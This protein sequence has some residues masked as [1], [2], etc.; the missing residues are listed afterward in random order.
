LQHYVYCPRQCGLI[1]V[2]DVWQ[3]NVFT[4]R[5]NILHEKVDTDTYE[6]RGTTKTVRGLRI[7][8]YKFGITGRCDVVEFKETENGKVV[9]PVEFK[10]GE[11]KEDI[12][13]K[14]QLCAQAICLEEML[15]ITIKQ[16]FFFYGKIR[17]RNIVDIDEELR[18][19]TEKII[20][21]VREIVTSKKIPV[22]EYQTKCRNCSLQSICQPK[23]MNKRKL[24][25][26]IK[27]LYI[28]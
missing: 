7:H 6:T 20:F 13:D 28:P 19:Q 25:Q 8:S 26:Y 5:G 2:D 3:D 18:T 11:P 4:V 17:R 22:A 9:L 16:G 14:V 27:G 12:S 24:E 23:A 21:A 10:S 15:N 1:H